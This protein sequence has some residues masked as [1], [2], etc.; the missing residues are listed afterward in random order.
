MDKDQSRSRW[1]WLPMAMP[2]VAKL[3][4]DARKRYGAEWVT[5]CWQHGVVQREPGWLFAGEGAIT[6]GVPVTSQAIEVWHQTRLQRP[7]AVLL[8]LRKPEASDAQ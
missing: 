4:V 3:M 8:E 6:L 7:D 1:S 2:G 5:T